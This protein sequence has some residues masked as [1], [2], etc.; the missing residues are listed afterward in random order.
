MLVGVI[1]GMP[2]PRLVAD[3]LRLIDGGMISGK[4]LN[5]P[6]SD[7]LK[8]K[9]SEGI[10]IEV[11]RTQCKDIR[12]NSDREAKYLDMVKS[13]ED[14]SKAH[15]AMA[16]ECAA[17]SQKALSLAHYERVVELDPT[18]N[19][20]WAALGYLQDK[21]G[22]WVKREIAA[23]AKGLV[24]RFNK[25]GFT[26]PYARAI[27]EA[28]DRINKAKHQVEDLIDRHYRNLGQPANRGL[29]ARAFFN[30]LTDIL[31]ID[32]ISKRL[33]E[34]L[35]KGRSTEFWMGLLAQ[36]PGNSA[37]GALIDL[38]LYANN[39][40]IEDECLTLLVRNPDSTEMAFSGFL[41]ALSKSE[42]RD[43][44]A[45]LLESLNDP[46]AVPVLIQSLITVKKVT[47]SNPNTVST[48][49]TMSFGNSS[50]TVNVPIQHQGVLQALTALTG[51]NYSYDK[52]KWMIW[53]ASEHADVNLD[54]RRN[55]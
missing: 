2:V 32:E 19:Q 27:A 5:D 38:A 42:L 16:L 20:S 7:V 29:E 9:T 41:G 44:A 30:N 36:M 34:D 46:R 48:G 43:R 14:T 47:Q 13:L 17:N 51:Q 55:Q 28:D 50:V 10:E 25:R 49:G 8:L 31:A 39:T 37:T 1:L 6:K 33:R 22:V 18:D 23:N 15:Q 3:T 35:A 24:E 11:N 54:L 53:Y 52:E 21:D 40:R 4:I 26:T 12:V 45:R